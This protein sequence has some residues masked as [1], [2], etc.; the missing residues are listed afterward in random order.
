M[1][2]VGDDLADVETVDVADDP[3][4]SRMVAVGATVSGSEKVS[5][6][7]YEN[8]EPHQSVRVRFSPAIDLSDSQGRAHL[9]RRLMTLH[10]GI[11]SDLDDAIDQRLAAIGSWPE[12]VDAPEGD[13]E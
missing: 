2:D 6:G 10:A 12:G 7:D 3:D 8:Y 9:R 11:Q 13:D 1:S 5:T 4:D